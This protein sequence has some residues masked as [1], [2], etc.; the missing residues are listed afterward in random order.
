MRTDSTMATNR[1]TDQMQAY[2]RWKADLTQAIGNYQKWL[3]VNKMSNPEVE[4]RIF[5]L[6]E[7]MKSDRLTIAFVAEFARG[8]TELINAIFFS[9][10]DR[11][12][13]PSEAG[14]T[15]M[16]P[17]E[18]IYDSQAD[19]SYI[20]LLPIETRLE[21]TSIQ[22][23]KK[24][25]INWTTITL[26]TNSSEKMAEAFKEVIRTKR[27]PAPVAAR[28][29]LIE[30]DE[31]EENSIVDIPMWRHA[32]ISFPHPLLR[33]GLSILDT[34]GLNALGNEPELTVNMLPNAQAVI[35]V[36]AADTGVTKSDMDMWTHHV[37]PLGGDNQHSRIVV[38]NKVDTL[39]DE[40]KGDEA[41]RNSINTQ[42]ASAARMLEIDPGKVFPVSAQKGL[43][44]KIRTDHDLLEKSNILALET[45]LSTEILPRK[46]SLMR[47]NIVNEIGDMITQSRDLV[48]SRL[49]EVNKQL[50]ELQSLSGKNEDVILHLMKK[51]REEQTVYHKSV[52][53]FQANKKT[54]SDQH[55]AL[56]N[57]LSLTR[58]D[59]LMAKTRKEMSG[60]WTTAGLK[61]SMKE[62]FDM[63]TESIG[64][65]GKQVDQINMLIQTIYREFQKQHG[66]SDVKPRLFSLAKYKRDLDRLYHEAEAYRKSPVT[67]MTE[68]SFVVK[69]FFISMVSHARNTFFQAHQDASSWGKAAMA[70]LVTRI[71]DHKSQMEKRL[72]SL[73]KINESRDTLKSRI[74]EL[75]AAADKLNVQLEELNGLME[76]LM[77]PLEPAPGENS[78]AASQV[79]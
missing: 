47:D 21:D 6:L 43:L 2:G 29:G 39:W 71:K 15:T 14:R 26:D 9:E 34:P 33:D 30:A 78:S 3:E 68:Q 67:T 56:L 52:E 59:Q 37:K 58:L 1:F 70:P 11:R 54:F 20:R 42:C 53:S 19:E 64:N 46:Q 36:L 72:E 10:Y 24:D 18:L 8:K 73:R 35:F 5:E 27:V 57:E 62:F 48:A 79:A 49:T 4:L 23:H 65:A 45:L 41:V 12:L 75:E 7:N 40:L 13:L 22:E 66:L 17:T 32:L 69:K 77:R 74:G 16:C 44:A 25:P 61:S 60:T 50:K 38:L 28:L 63:I 51:T 55:A 76:T 31:A